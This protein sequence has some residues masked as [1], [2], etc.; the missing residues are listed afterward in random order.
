MPGIR[1]K[2]I[3]KKLSFSPHDIV[4]PINSHK[5]NIACVLQDLSAD[6]KYRYT[7]AHLQ[8]I[9]D[10]QLLAITKP[11]EFFL[12]RAETICPPASP[13]HQA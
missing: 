1:G 6:L 10:D 13:V 2:R 4:V 7:H 12:S 8:T 3:A 11:E 5:D 9:G